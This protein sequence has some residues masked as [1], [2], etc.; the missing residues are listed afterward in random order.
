MKCESIQDRYARM[1][2]ILALGGSVSDQV[3]KQLE[4]EVQDIQTQGNQHVE[5]A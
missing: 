3:I 2:Q 4:R 1:L 5:C